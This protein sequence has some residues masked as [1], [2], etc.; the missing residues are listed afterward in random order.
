MMIHLFGTQLIF[1]FGHC[2]YL[3]SALKLFD[4]STVKDVVCWTAMMDGY[5]KNGCGVEGLQCF[6][7]MRS[8]GV[9]ID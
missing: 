6:M 3:K 5:V 8:M 2:G 4:E 7:E 1:C 9:R